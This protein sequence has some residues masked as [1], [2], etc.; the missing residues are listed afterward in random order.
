MDIE[1]EL[2]GTTF[3]WHE[4]KAR[5][6][7]RKHGVEFVEAATIFN[8]PL[9][10]VTDAGAETESRDKAIGFSTEGRL[11]AV[12]HVEAEGELIRI[13]SAWRASATEE[14]LYDR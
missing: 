7:E 8:D 3:V 13:I 10:V 2:A 5:K 4:A 1:F 14:R 9:L 12:V 11:L 6:N